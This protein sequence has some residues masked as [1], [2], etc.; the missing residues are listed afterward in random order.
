MFYLLMILNFTNKFEMHWCSRWVWYCCHCSE[1]F[2]NSSK[3]VSHSAVHNTSDMEIC[4]VCNIAFIVHLRDISQPNGTNIKVEIVD[5]G[6]DDDEYRYDDDE[7]FENLSLAIFEE[8]EEVHV[9]VFICSYCFVYFTTKNMLKVHMKSAHSKLYDEMEVYECY[10]CK[11][12]KSYSRVQDIKKHMRACHSVDTADISRFV[13]K[14]NISKVNLHLNS[15][16]NTTFECTSCDKTYSRSQDI[17]KHMRFVHNNDNIN[18][19]HYKIKAPLS[20][21]DFPECKRKTKKIYKCEICD[22]HFAEAESLVIHMNETHDISVNADQLVAHSVQVYACK[23]C[24]QENFLFLDILREHCLQKHNYQPHIYVCPQCNAYFLFGCNMGKHLTEVHADKI[25]TNIDLLNSVVRIG[26]ESDTLNTKIYAYDC[27]YCPMT[28]KR[29]RN[30]D[31]HFEMVHPG[32]SKGYT[33][34]NKKSGYLI[35]KE[36]KVITNI[37]NVSCSQCNQTFLCK[38]SLTYHLS[39]HLSN[40]RP[41]CPKCNESFDNLNCLWS[42]IFSN[43]PIAPYQCSLCSLSL[44]RKAHLVKHMAGEHGVALVVDDPEKVKQIKANCRVYVDGTLKYKCEECSMILNSFRSHQ[45]HMY[46]HNGDKPILCDQC[47][48]PFRSIS[49]LKT[50]ISIVHENIRRFRCEY[51]G[52][53]FSCQS[54]LIQ[55]IRIHTG[56]KPYVCDECGNRYAQ[57]ASLY[58]HKVTHAQNYCHV[59]TECG[60]AF[61]RVTRLRQHMKIHTGDRPPRSHVCDICHK[62]FRTNA[63]RKRHQLIHNPIRSYVCETCGS[64]F[65]LRKYLIQ[66]YKIHRDAHEVSVETVTDLGFA[67]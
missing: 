61:H 54:N 67:A 29:Q 18:P 59:C 43:H 16:T 66:H 5:V 20:L 65:T 40:A 24:D 8:K 51:C 42:H 30:F 38:E 56:E 10:M 60:R 45:T 17:I 46:T 6:E 15:V 31:A 19:N 11:N 48:K 12:P 49:T 14:A 26:K 4:D 37:E 22:E 27:N 53:A 62:G 25:W 33:L 28:F 7:D 9:D 47:S 55:H 2:D 21:I 36:N 32:K 13:R 63:E 58:S 50:H 39:E 35:K 3:L 1:H 57:Y 52:H 34:L 64:G 41:L 44:D 23:F